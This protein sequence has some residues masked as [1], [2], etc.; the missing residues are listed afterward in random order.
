MHIHIKITVQKSKH[1]QN[2]QERP[3]RRASVE[4]SEKLAVKHHTGKAQW[5]PNSLKTVQLDRKFYT[6]RSQANSQRRFQSHFN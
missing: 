4:G 5:Q 2:K 1:Y 6:S 3:E